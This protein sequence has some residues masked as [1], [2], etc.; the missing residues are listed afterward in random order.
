M[1][2]YCVDV[3]AFISITVEAEDEA[4]ARAAADNYVETSLAPSPCEIDGWN[5][6]R[7][8]ECNDPCR[9]VRTGGLAVDGESEVDVAEDEG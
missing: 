7:R 1:P 5:Q 9:I 6:V 8:D 3:K 4:S 2:L